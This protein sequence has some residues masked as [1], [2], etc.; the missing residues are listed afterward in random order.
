MGFTPSLH[1]S[2]TPSLPVRH[3]EHPLTSVQGFHGLHTEFVS[4]NSTDRRWNDFSI[5]RER[6]H[7]SF[8]AIRLQGKVFVVFPSR[9]YVILV[10]T[11]CATKATIFWVRRRS[12]KSTNYWTIR[13]SKWFFKHKIQ[14]GKRCLSV[15]GFLTKKCVKKTMKKKGKKKILLPVGFEP[16]TS[17]MWGKRLTHCATSTIL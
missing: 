3:F 16:L 4:S 9:T 8:F 12:K 5:I 15:Y 17:R 11:Y 2:F 1:H 7:G 10:V 14:K 13:G 6:L